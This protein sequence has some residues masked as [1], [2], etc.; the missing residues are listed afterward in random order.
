MKTRIRIDCA[1]ITPAIREQAHQLVM[2]TER[3]YS[4]LLAGKTPR[5]KLLLTAQTSS[6]LIARIRA[7]IQSGGEEMVN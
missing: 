7:L 2:E 6:L 1:V 3:E 5:Q 4:T